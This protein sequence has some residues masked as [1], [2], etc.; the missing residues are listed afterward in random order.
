MSVY[1]FHSDFGAA[2]LADADL[3]AVGDLVADAGGLAALGADELNLGGIDGGLDL[4]DAALFA[5]LA[6]L[7]MLGGDIDALDDDLGG[8]RIGDEDL[9]LL[10][11]SLPD[12]TTTLSSF[13]MFIYCALH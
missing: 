4:D 3:L 9:A 10:P 6:G 13:L 7:L 1:S 12:R 11:L 2:L 5:L 8:L